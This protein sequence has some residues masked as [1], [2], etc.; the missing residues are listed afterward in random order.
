MRPAC[1]G[2]TDGAEVT[3]ADDSSLKYTVVVG[4]GKLLKNV[5]ATATL[6]ELNKIPF[7]FHS[8]VAVTVGGETF[9]EWSEFEAYCACMQGANPRAPADACQPTH[10]SPR[11]ASR[12]DGARQ[13]SAR[14]ERACPSMP[15][16]LRQYESE[17]RRRPRV[18]RGAHTLPPLA[19][20][21]GL[22]HGHVCLACQ[23]LMRQ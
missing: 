22:V 7:R 3:N 5:R 12:P 1:A 14:H 23:V 2:V 21:R 16:P 6:D 8:Q 4:G 15:L 18:R 9:G 10:A 11:I 20:G 17:R 13:L 19:V